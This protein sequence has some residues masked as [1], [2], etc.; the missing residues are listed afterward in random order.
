MTNSFEIAVGVAVGTAASLGMLALGGGIMHNNAA[1]DIPG[2]AQQNIDACA[3]ALPTTLREKSQITDLPLPCQQFSVDF[4]A[5]DTGQYYLMEG[6]TFRKVVKENRTSHDLPYG[7]RFGTALLIGGIFGTATFNVGKDLRERAAGSGQ[8]EPIPPSPSQF[9]W[10]PTSAVRRRQEGYRIIAPD[11][12][13]DDDLHELAMEVW[14]MY[15][16]LKGKQ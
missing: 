16:Q 1:Q 6:D 11:D 2:L 9:S 8:R 5:S 13:P 4:T 15:R 14:P 12:L 3:V 10:K 7:V